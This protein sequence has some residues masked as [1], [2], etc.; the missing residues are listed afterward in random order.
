METESRASSYVQCKHCLSHT[1]AP[2]VTTCHLTSA[3]GLAPA[4]TCKTLIMFNSKS[5]V[6]ETNLGAHQQCIQS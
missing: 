2:I 3:L 1:Y 5:W 6:L 4:K